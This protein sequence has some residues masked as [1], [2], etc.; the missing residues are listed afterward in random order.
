MPGQQPETAAHAAGLGLDSFELPVWTADFAIS[1]IRHP[2][3]R[4][5]PAHR[6]LREIIA[7]VCRRAYP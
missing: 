4:A 7:A 3:L 2:R 6:W 1:A 5:D